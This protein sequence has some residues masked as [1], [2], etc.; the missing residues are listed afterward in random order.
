MFKKC[1]TSG[2][3]KW[4]TSK[5]LPSIS[6]SFNLPWPQLQPHE[7]HLPIMSRNIKDRY[8]TATELTTTEN[9]GPLSNLSSFIRRI[10]SKHKD[11]YAMYLYHL[12]KTIQAS[13]SKQIILKFLGKIKMQNAMKHSLEQV[14]MQC[15]C[16]EFQ[17][18]F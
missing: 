11:F 10:N 7:P 12:Q 1:S 13:K 16:I 2:F 5:I 8:K 15:K 6:R 17:S 14:I 9:L 3:K 4:S 18:S